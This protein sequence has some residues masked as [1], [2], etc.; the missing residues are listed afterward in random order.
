MGNRNSRISDCAMENSVGIGG[1]EEDTQTVLEYLHAVLGRT[2]AER[3]LLFCCSKIKTM[4]TGIAVTTMSPDVASLFSALL[5]LFSVAGFT[6]ESKTREPSP[7]LWAEIGSETRRNKKMIANRVALIKT[8]TAFFSSLDFKIQEKILLE[9]QSDPRKT[10]AMGSLISAV[11]SD[12]QTEYT[13]A[14]TLLLNLFLTHGEDETKILSSIKPNSLSALLTRLHRRTA[15]EKTPSLLAPTLILLWCVSENTRLPPSTSQQH[16]VDSAI[17]LAQLIATEKNG[18]ITKLADILLFILSSA[19]KTNRTLATP[20]QHALL[21]HSQSLQTNSP[22]EFIICT[23]LSVLNTNP[24][25]ENSLETIANL[26]LHTELSPVTTKMFFEALKTSPKTKNAKA[27]S[28]L[29]STVLHLKHTPRLLLLLR[30]NEVLLFSTLKR[31]QTD[32]KTTATLYGASLGNKKKLISLLETIPDTEDT[33]TL[34]LFIAKQT[35]S[36]TPQP[37]LLFTPD[38]KTKQWRTDI[39]RSVARPDSEHANTEK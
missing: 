30:A 20:L 18:T 29:I 38:K 11:S 4:Y 2:P 28:S 12:T 16:V 35:P 9:F 13:A 21:T 6:V 15:T 8:T 33:K 1:V 17:S 5:E 36:L 34:A 32:S 19:E 7:V 26:S 23:L 31:I 39:A 24:N 27:T 10:A 3:E 14:S 37:L 22:T 25:T